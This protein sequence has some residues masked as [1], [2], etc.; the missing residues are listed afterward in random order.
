V[1][2]DIK[3]ANLFLA[4]Q[5]DGRALVKILDFGIAKRLVSRAQ[6]GLTNPARSLGSPWYM[7][8]EQMMDPS[9][10]DVRTDVWSL[11]ILLFELLT[12]DHPFDGEEI[13]EVCAQVMH[14]S[15]PSLFTYRDDVE[16][17]LDALVLRCL[18]KN[19]DRRFPSVGA[20]AEALREFSAPPRSSM[21]AMA[22]PRSWRRPRPSRPNLGSLEPI[23]DQLGLRGSRW[24][25]VLRAA[26]VATAVGVTGWAGLTYLPTPAVPD[27]SWPAV[28]RLE[29]PGD[30][31]LYPGPAAAP[32]APRSKQPSLPVAVPREG[33]NLP[34]KSASVVAT[35]ADSEPVLTPR[36]IR[37]RTA[38]Y[39]SWLKA[40]GLLRI[41]EA[42]AETRNPY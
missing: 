42:A 15:P 31:V 3:P 39:E 10:V 36:E 8:P 4:R 20:L 14:A 19:P 23:A 6:R 25:S 27:V 22:V 34:T 5:P 26:G 21:T 37:Q 38:R 13:P 2:R 28:R 1:H 35:P 40:Q 29:L 17:G 24:S 32:L 18:E 41:E 33:P 9:R 11:G 12:G 30:P 7:S 16:P